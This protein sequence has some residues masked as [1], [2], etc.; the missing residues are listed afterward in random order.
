MQLFDFEVSL[1]VSESLKVILS[2]MV[3]DVDGI[4]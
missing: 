4:C 2:V 3:G 1:F